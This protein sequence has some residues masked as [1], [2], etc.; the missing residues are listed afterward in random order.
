MKAA[1]IDN[2]Q[3]EIVEALRGIGASVEIT[4]QVGKGFPDLAVGFRGNTYLLEV[5]GPKGKLTPDQVRFHQAWNGH[6]AVVRTVD[7][8]LVTVGAI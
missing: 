4:S 8:A 2:N 3:R 5:K 1:K 6:I 7:E